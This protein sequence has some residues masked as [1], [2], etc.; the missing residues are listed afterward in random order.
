MALG[1]LKPYADVID[2]VGVGNHETASEKYHNVDPTQIL[3]HQLQQLGSPCA[4]GGY[5][6]W[7][8]VQFRGHDR[9][10]WSWS[11]RDH[12]G[13]GGAAPVTK[14]M[15]DFARFGLWVEGADCLWVGH[16]HNRFLD[17]GRREFCTA[18]GTIR[19]RDVL[20]VMTGSYYPGR[21]GQTSE[22]AMLNGRKGGWAHDS[23]FSPQAMGGHM[24]ELR[25]LARNF[26]SEI[27]VR[28]ISEN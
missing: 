16:K 8:R 3:V 5:E 22:D 23:G 19:H 25:P 15:I 12:H 14:G 27:S 6:G 17:W 10:Y 13:M 26:R 2:V 1:I 7:Y 9:K 28:I 20:H 24:V 18:Q 21:S 4:Y 11:R